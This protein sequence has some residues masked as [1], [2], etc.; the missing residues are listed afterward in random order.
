MPT[1]ARLNGGVNLLGA[2]ALPNPPRRPEPRDVPDEHGGGA[3]RNAVAL[4]DFP[5]TVIH[6]MVTDTPVRV[7]SM[8][9]LGAFANVFAIECFIDELADAAGEDP[10]GYRLSVLSDPRARAVI[11]TAAAMAK[12]EPQEAG[13]GRA[14]GIGFSRYKNR[15]GYCALV[16]EVEVEEE[17]RVRRVWCAV[18]AGLAVNPDG[19]INQVEGGIIQATSWTVKEQVRFAGGRIVSDTWDQYPTLRFSEVPEVEV[20]LIGDPNNPPLG[21]G[22]VSQGPTAGAI[23]N[24]LA[25]ALGVRIRDLPFTRDRILAAVL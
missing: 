10:V 25:R 22:E 14:R 13:T 18:D 20:R 9:G 2:E 1:S 4:Y 23:G 7:S 21:V 11:E 5:Q 24:A 12:W 3:S 6:R 8:R 17:V 16:A 19:V 15:S